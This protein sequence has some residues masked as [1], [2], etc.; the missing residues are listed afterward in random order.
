M[1]VAMDHLV[2]V[3]DTVATGHEQNSQSLR[4]RTSL[5]ECSCASNAR[6]NTE[7]TTCDSCFNLI[8]HTTLY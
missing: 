5:P 4:T 1:V 2:L 3:E 6:A 8:S 7:S